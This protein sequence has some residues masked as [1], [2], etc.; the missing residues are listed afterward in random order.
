MKGVRE[1]KYG[2]QAFLRIRGQFVSQHFPP[3]TPDAEILEWQRNARAKGQLRQ[4]QRVE[5]FTG[6]TFAEDAATYLRTATSMP[7]YEDRAY[8]IGQWAN[9]F[10]GRTRA[11]I[12]PV[13]IRTQLETWRQTLSASSCNKRRTALM[14]FFTRLNGKGG[15]NPVRD[16]EKYPEESEPRAQTPYT[17][18][19]VLALM[20]PS[21]TRCRLRV[22]LT[23]GWPHAQVK[24][25]APS[26]LD[27]DR[28]RAYVTPR[29]KGKGRK[30]TWLPLLP[31][32]VAAL[33]DFVRWDAFTPLDSKGEPLPWSHSA[34]HKSWTLAL[35][36]LNERRAARKQ[37]PLHIRPYDLRHTFGT[38]LAHRIT[39]ERAL[40]ELMMHS[41]VEQTRHYTDEATLG[42]VERAL[43]ALEKAKA[44]LPVAPE[45]APRRKTA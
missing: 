38:W 22:I 35:G 34:M 25:L 15:Y 6:P 27:L 26:H 45:V 24:R 2:R 12:T 17:I 29:R 14:S 30:G 8:H 11:S 43:E 41:R 31:S 5:T 20:P 44:T 10:A 28:R 1:R 9:V 13:E 4:P 21:K 32:A 42:R 33:R 23:T 18:Y 40:Q 36:K 39:D 3:D 16:V 19:R 7:S 37:P